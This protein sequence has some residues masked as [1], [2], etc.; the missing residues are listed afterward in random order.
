MKPL[1]II[2]KITIKTESIDMVKNEFQ[3]LLEPTRLEAGCIVYKLN[4]DDNNPNIL[5]FYE[6]WES[7]DLWQEHM[8]GENL[9][10][11]NNAIAEHVEDVQIFEMTSLD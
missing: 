3:K 2:A 11:C 8:K 6:E 1:I 10:Q 9:V 7:R 5:I 4:Q